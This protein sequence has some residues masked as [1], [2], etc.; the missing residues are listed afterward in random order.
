[1]KSV[2]LISTEEPVSALIS[3]QCVKMPLQCEESLTASWL[4]HRPPAPLK[5]ARPL[6]ADR[7]APQRARTLFDV[8]KYSWKALKSSFKFEADTMVLVWEGKLFGIF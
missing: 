4:R 5:V 8:F 3:L 1:M 2:G 6:E 7:P